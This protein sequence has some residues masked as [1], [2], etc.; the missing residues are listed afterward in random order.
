MSIPKHQKEILEAMGVAL[1]HLQ[2]AETILRFCLS[3]VFQESSPLTIELLTEQREVERTKTI[4]HFLAELRKRV[5]VDESLDDLLKEILKNRN[6]F[7]HDLSRVPTWDFD[8]TGPSPGA[9]KFVHALIRQTESLL[10]V[11]S[12][13]VMAWQEQIGMSEPGLPNHEWFTEID[14]KYKPLAER[15]FCAKGT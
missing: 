8:K 2:T 6:D 15:L 13:V 14:Q 4:G 5:V 1:I 11:F 12:G 9:K 3:F 10:K 7:I